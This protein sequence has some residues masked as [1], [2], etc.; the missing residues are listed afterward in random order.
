MIGIRHIEFNRAEGLHDECGWRTFY[1]WSS[2]HAFVMAAARTAPADG[3][4]HKCDVAVK[5]TD[6]TSF[7]FRFEL[8]NAHAFSTTSV[9]DEMRF[10]LSFYAGRERPLHLTETQYRAMLQ[11]QEHIQPGTSVWMAQ[12]IDG[13]YDLGVVVRA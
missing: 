2:L 11:A 5:W 8:T 10:K 6:G 4:V 9:I 12:I 1:S 7:K 13:G 3:T